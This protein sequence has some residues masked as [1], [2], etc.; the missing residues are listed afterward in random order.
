MTRDITSPAL[1]E[2]HMR[3]AHV[4]RSRAVLNALSKLPAALRRATHSVAAFF[5]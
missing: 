4:I 5:V 1:I 3:D 2:H